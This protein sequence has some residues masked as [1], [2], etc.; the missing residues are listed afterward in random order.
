MVYGLVIVIMI[1]RQ[2]QM[3]Q[4][5]HDAAEVQPSSLWVPGVEVLTPS[6]QIMHVAPLE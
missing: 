6:D 1:S 4:K 3:H 5:L 2:A